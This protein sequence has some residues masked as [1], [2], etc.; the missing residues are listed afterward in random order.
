MK[1]NG[2][3]NVMNKNGVEPNLDRNQPDRTGQ[4]FSKFRQIITGLDGVD[5]EVIWVFQM[6]FI[7]ME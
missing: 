1:M 4:R 2:Y 5:L 7:W 6:F 3:L